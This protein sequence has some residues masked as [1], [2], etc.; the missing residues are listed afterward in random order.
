M[1]EK[2]ISIGAMLRQLAGMEGTKDLSAWENRFLRNVLE[3]SGEG[4]RTSVLSGAQVE[5]I[6]QIYEKHCAG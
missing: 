3:R 4:K 1:A 2:I 5:Q 6:S